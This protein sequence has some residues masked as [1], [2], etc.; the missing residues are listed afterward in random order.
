MWTL[1]PVLGNMKER[2]GEV[3]RAGDPIILVHCATS[4][5]LYTDRIDYRNEY[6]IEYEVSALCAATKSKT[7]VL[8]NE[9]KG[10]QVRENV[11]KSVP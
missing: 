1:Q 6:G 3:V 11:H 9:Y 5:Y 10:T 2:Q 8:A 7:Q 4:Q